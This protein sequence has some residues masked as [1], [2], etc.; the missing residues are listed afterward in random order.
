LLDLLNV[1]Y[2]LQRN[3][4][5]SNLH[6]RTTLPDGVLTSENASAIMSPELMKGF[7]EGQTYLHLAKTFGDLDIYEFSGS[8]PSFY[9]LSQESLDQS[10]IAIQTTTTLQN[11]WNFAKDEGLSDWQSVAYN[12]T[13]PT[14]SKPVRNGNFE[15]SNATGYYLKIESPYIQ[16]QHENIYRIGF[17]GS[18]ANT[19]SLNVTVVQYAQN[20]TTLDN[21]VGKN[22]NY[23]NFTNFSSVCRFEPLQETDCFKIQ[24]WLD[25]WNST[26]HTGLLQIADLNVTRSIYTLNTIGLDSLINKSVQNQSAS[27]LNVQNLNPSKTVLSVNATHPFILAMSQA[28]DKSWIATANGVQLKPV[29]LYLGLQGYEIN[30]TGQLQIT[31]EYKPQTWFNY[32]SVISVTS[33]IVLLVL[34]AYVS[35]DR[36]LQVVKKSEP[37]TFL[38]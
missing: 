8:L 12:N 29:T 37:P 7:F 24:V 31:L 2:I 27:I 34:L 22:L 33:A 6:G 5:I 4:V 9:T 10:N 25:I 11:E 13:G 16:S 20:L 28:F 21:Y 35:R 17:D 15:Q 14:V 30:K 18:G 19:A 23:G 36:L 38:G 26:D 3:D 32:A 1:K